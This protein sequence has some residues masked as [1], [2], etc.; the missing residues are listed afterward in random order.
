ML[1]VVSMYCTWSPD[2]QSCLDTRKYSVIVCIQNACI[3]NVYM[4]QLTIKTLRQGTRDED[5]CKVDQWRK[6]NFMRLHNALHLLTRENKCT[7]NTHQ[8]KKWFMPTQLIHGSN[9]TVP[10]FVYLP[11]VA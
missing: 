4:S 1:V 7:K 9:K 11:H 8:S 6:Q 10:L 2:L 3:Q 5:H